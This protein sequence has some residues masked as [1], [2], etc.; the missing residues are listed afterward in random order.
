[1]CSTNFC[2][3]LTIFFPAPLPDLGMMSEKLNPTY[4]QMGTGSQSC[5]D[6]EASLSLEIAEATAG[7]FQAWLT[8]TF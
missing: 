4:I 6:S 1:M 5:S 2:L 3:L 7:K 8:C